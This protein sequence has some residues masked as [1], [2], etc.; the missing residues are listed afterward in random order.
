[1]AEQ[2][3]ISNTPSLNRT[4]SELNAAAPPFEFRP[5]APAQQ[6]AAPAAPVRSY[7]SVV[8]RDSSA[9]SQGSSQSS[10]TRNRAP[11]RSSTSSRSP[12]GSRPASAAPRRNP[13][14]SSL[15]FNFNPNALPFVNRSSS[16]PETP[17]ANPNAAPFFPR[18][19]SPAEVI[20]EEQETGDLTAKDAIADNQNH[21]NASST[22][23]LASTK[24]EESLRNGF[25][26]HKKETN[27]VQ[28]P[29]KPAPIA[30]D[31]SEPCH[32]GDPPSSPTDPQE[33]PAEAAPPSEQPAEGNVPPEKPE[34]VASPLKKPAEAVSPPEQP[35]ASTT[36]TDS[37]DAAASQDSS[38]DLPH[39]S[40][41]AHSAEQMRKT[42]PADDT[43]ART[44]PTSPAEAA[45]LSPRPHV[46]EAWAA[47]GTATRNDTVA[48]RT[49]PPSVEVNGTAS[50]PA[51]AG[52][53]SDLRPAD[54][55]LSVE[56]GLHAAMGDS[57]GAL[58]VG[59]VSSGVTPRALSH[60]MQQHE[61]S[62]SRLRTAVHHEIVRALQRLT[63]MPISTAVPQQA[64]GV[65]SGS[66]GNAA[67][68]SGEVSLAGGVTSASGALRVDHSVG[69]PH[70]GRMEQAACMDHFVARAHADAITAHTHSAFQKVCRGVSLLLSTVCQES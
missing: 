37:S 49:W 5:S 24:A 1:M 39:T 42:A 50:P 36:T 30:D 60:S 56:S 12:A 23:D 3:D 38:F 47:D 35:A 57:T 15:N 65:C 9:R 11:T 17:P 69:A 19:S 4:D 25:H 22:A 48:T 63:L 66:S 31:A 61:R 68:A 20:E 59:N 70:A 6:P 2:P 18:S 21:Q 8:G 10:T 45:P 54:G 46:S 14:S 29:N 62:V 26:D 41:L 58:L 55:A 51:G 53:D 27:G 43:T 32:A 52:D 7:A 34:A 44:D 40:P 33:Q 64:N 13:S 16:S 67:A 28:K